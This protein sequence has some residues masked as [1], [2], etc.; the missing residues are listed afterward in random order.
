MLRIRLNKTAKGGARIAKHAC[1]LNCIWCHSDYFGHTNSI[2]AIT[3]TDFAREVDRLLEISG[4]GN[5]HVRIAGAGE[6][7]LVGKR[8]LSDLTRRLKSLPKVSKVKMTTNGTR[9]SGMAEELRDAGMDAVTVSLNSTNREH[10]KM[11][12][13]HDGLT[14]AIE[15]VRAAHA[16]GLPVKVN[17]IYSKINERELPDYEK[18]SIQFDGMPI[19]FFDLLSTNEKPLGLYLPL[20]RLERQIRLLGGACSVRF[21]PYLCKIYRLHSGAVFEVKVAG[22]VN[23]CPNRSC[24]YRKV[25]LEGCRHS[26]RIGLDGV[27]KPCGVRNDNIVHLF[28]REIS[29]AQIWRALHSGGKVGYPQ[30]H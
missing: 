9:L 26:V 16:A 13:Q 20:S 21:V 24:G 3:N 11:Y 4:S 14:A 22:K 23:T 1:N 10:F 12:S 15:G 27:L 2:L 7:T 29:D 18:L 28:S 8:E 17:A 5:A 6:P 19:K 25:C 30:E